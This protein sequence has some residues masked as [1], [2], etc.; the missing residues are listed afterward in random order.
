MGTR[1]RF[2]WRL[3]PILVRSRAGRLIAQAITRFTIESTTTMS[4]GKQSFVLSAANPR[5]DD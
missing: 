1:G 4:V 3:L 2:A 5:L